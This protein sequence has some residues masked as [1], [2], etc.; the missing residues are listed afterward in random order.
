MSSNTLVMTDA[1]A[2]LAELGNRGWSVQND[3]KQEVVNE[4]AQHGVAEAWLK[5]LGAIALH[6]IWSF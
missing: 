4:S 6:I 3:V 2:E 1:V 5:K